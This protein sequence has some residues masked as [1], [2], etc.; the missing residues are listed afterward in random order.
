LVE[1]IAKNSQNIE[2]KISIDKFYEI[3]T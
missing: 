3:V 1:V 2:W